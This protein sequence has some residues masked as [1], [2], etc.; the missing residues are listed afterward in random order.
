MDPVV[1]QLV[2]WLNGFMGSREAELQ[3]VSAWR[4][5]GTGLSSETWIVELSSADQ[6][7]VERVVFRVSPDGPA[8]FPAYDEETEVVAITAAAAE[9]VPVANVIAAGSIPALSRSVMALGYIDGAIPKDV[10][11]YPSAGFLHDAPASGQ[12]RAYAGF[13]DLLSRIHQ[14]TAGRIR[15]GALRSFDAASPSDDLAFWSSYAS[16]LEADP[17]DLA[18]FLTALNFLGENRPSRND[19][20]LNWGDAKISNVIF[21]DNY[22]PKGVLDW[23]MATLGPREVDLGFWLIYDRWATEGLGFAP[24]PGALDRTETIARYEERTGVSTCD[25]EYFEIWGAV[26]LGLLQLRLDRLLRCSGRLPDRS[27]PLHL[28]VARIL[29]ELLTSA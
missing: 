25:V 21:G 7:D 3:A 15:P 2:S 20:V 28:P 26:R 12:R 19:H 24:L 9:G 1:G 4:P 16:W 10:P 27:G 6:P 18:P 13:V 14:V 5:S 11:A 29:E 17:S 22:E 23:E 8:V